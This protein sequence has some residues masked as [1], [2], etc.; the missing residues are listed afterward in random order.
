MYLLLTVQDLDK[1]LSIRKAQVDKIEA[2][3]AYL[4]GNSSGSNDT[5]L[6]EE[7]SPNCCLNQDL[8]KLTER[9]KLHKEEKLD[10]ETVMFNKPAN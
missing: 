2:T 5:M 10:Y 6:N 4:Q 1:C 7:I 3:Y 8:L 9:I